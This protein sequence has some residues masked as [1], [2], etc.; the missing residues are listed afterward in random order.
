[1]NGC[2]FRFTLRVTMLDLT[3]MFGLWWSSTKAS[4]TVGVS[5]RDACFATIAKRVVYWSRSDLPSRRVMTCSELACSSIL[6]MSSW[7]LGSILMLLMLKSWVRYSD[8]QPLFMRVS[9][10]YA[11][12][13]GVL[14][15]VSRSSTL[16]SSLPMH[17]FSV[18]HF[19]IARG[20]M[21]ALT[22]SFD[23]RPCMV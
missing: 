20:G 12:L 19:P 14:G 2:I 6:R 13:T 15:E 21:A 8:A 4:G 11:R 17:L 10:M 9:P 18:E 5:S 3:L 1:M 7:H 16:S 23:F 22:M